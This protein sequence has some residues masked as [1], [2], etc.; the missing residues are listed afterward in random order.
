MGRITVKT[1]A[2]AVGVSA[3]T[4]SNA[5]NRPDQ[6]SA[7]LRAKILSKADELGYAG[8]D[9]AARQLRSGHAG[10]VGVLLTQR[11]SYAFNDPYAIGCL[12]GLSEVVERQQ[13]SIMLMPLWWSDGQMDLTAIRQANV[14]AIAS[15]CVADPR[16]AAELARIRG[17]RM[18]G[19]DVNPDPESWWVA[20]DDVQAGRLVGEHLAGLGH[21]DVAVIVDTPGPPGQARRLAFKDVTCTDCRSRL[22][23]LRELI[24]GDLVVVTGGYNTPRS[25]RSATEVL[26]DSG[27]R[28]S[29]IVGLSDVLA[30]GALEVLAQRGLSAPDDFAVAGF[31]DIPA[32]EMAGLTTVRQPYQE[33][34]RLIGELLMQPERDERQIVLPIELVNRATTGSPAST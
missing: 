24:T 13:T 18:I 5:Y 26:L 20:I 9:A 30:L 23:G 12:A 6:L 7:E 16:P 28:F 33:K 22:L 31:D 1:L 10:A 29:A 25:G 19:T 34:G 21:R 14:D 27:E 15:L 3:S 4:V 17:L 11:L 8:P 2:E 32:A